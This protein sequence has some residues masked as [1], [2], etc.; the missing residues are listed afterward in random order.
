MTDTSK[1]GG[2]CDHLKVSQMLTP[3]KLG[4]RKTIGRVSRSNIR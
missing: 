1:Q 2:D 4:L 3:R